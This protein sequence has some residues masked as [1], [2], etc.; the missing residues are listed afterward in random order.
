MG[1]RAW[2]Q[3]EEEHFLRAPEQVFGPRRR[4]AL[5]VIRDRIGLDYFGIDCGLDPDGHLV[6]FEVNAAMLVHDQNPEF[7]YKDRYI[8]R[9]KRAFDGMLARLARGN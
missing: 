1:G 3:A 9:I 8:R 6:V 5:R 4:A 2:M 7:P